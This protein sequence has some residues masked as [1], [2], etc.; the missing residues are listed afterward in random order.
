MSAYQEAVHELARETGLH[1]RELAEA[2]EASGMDWRDAVHGIASL[3][4]SGNQKAMRLAELEVMRAAAVH[5]T[6]DAGVVTG[7][8]G[9]AERDR[10]TAPSR[11]ESAVTTILQGRPDL[12]A[13][14]LERLG[15][16]EVAETAQRAMHDAMQ[17]TD[18]VE[19]WERELEPGAC[20]MCRWWARDGRVWPK[21]HPMPTHKG[22]ECTQQ[23][24]TR[25]RG[26]ILETG[27]T[28][29]LAR[30]EAKAQGH[31]TEWK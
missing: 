30:A 8:A 6:V 12:Q 4:L 10:W 14:A 26:T 25:E 7:A 23:I 11:L 17:T 2:I 29:R 3:V 9:T 1:A 18:G 24:V 19:G 16:S 5:P 22:C 13:S 31:E 27:Y 15:R 21:A 20:E 28:K